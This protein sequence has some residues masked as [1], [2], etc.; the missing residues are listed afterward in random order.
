MASIK[1]T[2]SIDSLITLLKAEKSPVVKEALIQALGSIQDRKVSAAVAPLLKDDATAPLAIRVLGSLGDPSAIPTLAAELKADRPTVRQAVIKTL[3]EIDSADAV[4]PLLD[5]YPSANDAEKVLIIA[6][7]NRHGDPRSFPLL[8]RELQ[9]PKVYP[10]VRRRAALALGSMVAQEAIEPLVK[11]ILNTAE[12][13]G[14]RLTCIQALANYSERDDYA[15][16]GLIGVM[17]DKRMAEPAALALSRITRRYFGTDKTKWEN[18][19]H[20]WRQERDKS[21]APVAH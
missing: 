14:L 10:A 9:D 11:I 19:F 15:I 1:G 17:A 20:Q 6:S 12:D 16:A 21:G 18:W 13:N 8:I 5:C 7:L 3:G 4:P 2:E